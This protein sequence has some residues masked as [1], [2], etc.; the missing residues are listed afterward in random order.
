MRGKRLLRILMT[1]R[2]I[3]WR[4]LI[5]SRIPEHVAKRVDIIIHLKAEGL[6]I[7]DIAR[8]LDRDHTSVMH[9]VTPGRRERRLARMREY[10]RERR[11]AA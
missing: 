11:A 10:T 6:S 5:A 1:E 9:W 8:L 7:S 4:D 3:G 2:S